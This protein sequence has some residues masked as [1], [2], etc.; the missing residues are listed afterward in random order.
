MSCKVINKD[1]NLFSCNKEDVKNE[2]MDIRT[3][4]YHADYDIDALM[5]FYN[6]QTDKLMLVEDVE[7]FE[8][9]KVAAE[10]YL[11]LN[12]EQRN[13]FHNNHIPKN[14]VGFM[15]VLKEAIYIREKKIK[16]EAFNK[17]VQCIKK[18][19]AKN[20]IPYD[21]LDEIIAIYDS[22]DHG[23][24]VFGLIDIYNHG[25]IQGKRFERAKRKKIKN[26][27]VV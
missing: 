20:C 12:R 1:L 25:L 7:H 11:T 18:M 2:W 19:L 10:G 24:N 23:S 26:E 9:L 4:T 14:I 6:P 13:E 16:K 21:L 8:K 27:A 5:I 22:R 15:N 17:K 3:D